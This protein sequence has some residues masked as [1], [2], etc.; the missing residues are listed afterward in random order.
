MSCKKRCLKLDSQSNYT[1]ALIYFNE[2]QDSA[3]EGGH[4][5]LKAVWV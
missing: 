3:Y 2:Y 4:V 5:F 1:R